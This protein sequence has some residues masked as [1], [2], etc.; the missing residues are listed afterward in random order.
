MVQSCY[1]FGYKT[2]YNNRDKC[3]YVTL[4]QIHDRGEKIN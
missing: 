2:N 3:S 4:F 1:V